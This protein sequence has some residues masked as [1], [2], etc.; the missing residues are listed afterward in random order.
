MKSPFGKLPSLR[1]RGRLYSPG[2]SHR[3]QIIHSVSKTDFF[4]EDFGRRKSPATPQALLPAAR[5]RAAQ[6]P[7]R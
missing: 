2:E 6:T 4:T 3:H 1:D 5:C 7:R